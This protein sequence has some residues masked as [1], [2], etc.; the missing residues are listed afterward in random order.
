MALRQAGPTYRELVYELQHD[1][2]VRVDH[3]TIRRDL[4]QLPERAQEKADDAKPS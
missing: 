1:Q 2:P 4:I 3:T